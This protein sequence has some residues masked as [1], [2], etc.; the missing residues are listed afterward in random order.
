[1]AFLNT[2][3]AAVI[4]FVKTVNIELSVLEKDPN[5]RKLSMALTVSNT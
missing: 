1:M 4:R 3:I 2:L 5:T